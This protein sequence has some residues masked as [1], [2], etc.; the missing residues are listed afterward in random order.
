MGELQGIQVKNQ[1]LKMQ[2]N[3]LIHNAIYTL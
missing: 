3:K 2:Q 1:S